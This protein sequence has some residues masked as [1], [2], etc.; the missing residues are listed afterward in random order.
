MA[1]LISPFI[2]PLRDITI[3]MGKST[4]YKRH[5]LENNYK[6]DKLLKSTSCEWEIH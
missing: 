5:E 6:W 4:I 1:I 2:I 3:L